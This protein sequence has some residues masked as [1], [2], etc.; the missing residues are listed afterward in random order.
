MTQLAQFYI[1]NLRISEPL[2]RA[3]S[4]STDFDTLFFRCSTK[5]RN[6]NK[7]IILNLPT[8]LFP[9]QFVDMFVMCATITMSLPRLQRFINYQYKTDRSG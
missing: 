3:I 5:F 6:I 2:T 1:N 4:V 8:K 7:L 9:S